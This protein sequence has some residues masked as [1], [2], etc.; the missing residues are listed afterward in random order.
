MTPELAKMLELI[1]RCDDWAL[2]DALV[3]IRT[4]SFDHLKPEAAEALTTLRAHIIAEMG[5]RVARAYVEAHGALK[6]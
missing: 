1:P 3:T 2:T 6:H 5:E 4:A